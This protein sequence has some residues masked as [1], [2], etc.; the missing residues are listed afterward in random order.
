MAFCPEI[1]KVRTL[2]TLQ[3]YNFMCKPP[4]E[5]KSEANF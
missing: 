1:A 3:G 5:M 4:V 2:A